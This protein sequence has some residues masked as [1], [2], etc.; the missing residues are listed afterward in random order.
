MAKKKAAANDKQVET[1]KESYFKML[2]LNAYREKTFKFPSFF[3]LRF[4]LSH[5]EYD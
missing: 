1:S 2:I 5:P 4:Y 3:S